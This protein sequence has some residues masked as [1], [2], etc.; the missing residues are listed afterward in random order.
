MTR[1]WFRIEF[2]DIT[3]YKIEDEKNPFNI[4][5]NNMRSPY[6]SLNNSL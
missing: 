3:L 5:I 4:Q 6:M 2:Q 1:K